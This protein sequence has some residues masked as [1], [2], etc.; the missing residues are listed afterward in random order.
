MWPTGRSMSPSASIW[1][2]SVTCWACRVGDGGEGAKQWMATLAELRNRGVE[3]VCIVACDGL[4]GFAAGDR[5]DLAPRDRPAPRRSPRAGLAALRVE[6]A[7]VA[8][9]QGTAD[10][11]YRRDDGRGRGSLRGFRRGLR[12][13]VSG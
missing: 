13:Q 8:D 2:V 3:D 5:G 9:H 11:L 6:N 7:L 4:K 10:R 12:R 1:P